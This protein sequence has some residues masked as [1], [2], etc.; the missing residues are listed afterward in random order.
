MYEPMAMIAGG[1]CHIHEITNI[2]IWNQEEKS[3]AD[4][5]SWND[6]GSWDASASVYSIQESEALFNKDKA[7]K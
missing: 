6:F 1:Y 7:L 3:K 4:S 5:Q 2:T